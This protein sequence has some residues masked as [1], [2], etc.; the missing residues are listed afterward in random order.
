MR[1]WEVFSLCLCLA[2]F[3]TFL[4]PCVGFILV[5]IFVGCLL[6]PFDMFLLCLFMTG[7]QKILDVST[8]VSD[9]L[10]LAFNDIKYFHLVIGKPSGFT[11]RPKSV[12]LGEV[13]GVD[14]IKYLGVLLLAINVSCFVVI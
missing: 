8:A 3:L 12:Y 7:L 5:S 4:S 6:Y 13:P 9:R 10:S 1:V 11:I 14:S 2:R